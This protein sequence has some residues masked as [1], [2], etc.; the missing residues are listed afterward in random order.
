MPSTDLGASIVYMAKRSADSM[1]LGILPKRNWELPSASTIVFMV[2]E[3]SEEEM[4]AILIAYD[5]HKMWLRAMT[6]DAKG[7]TPHAVGWL[8]RK[9]EESGYNGVKI[10]MKSDQ[11]HAIKALQ[12][13]SEH[14]KT[15]RNGFD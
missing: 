9:I 15:F 12:K 2:P 10:T 14:Q 6:A 5:N 13:G 4:D 3:V 8:S 1:Q 11:A 7:P